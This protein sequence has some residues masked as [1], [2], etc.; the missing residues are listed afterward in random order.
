MSRVVFYLLDQHCHNS[1]T[2]MERKNIKAHIYTTEQTIAWKG[3]PS[4]KEGL[5]TPLERQER[6]NERQTE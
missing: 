6:N 4:R 5:K 3:G 2:Q 1:S